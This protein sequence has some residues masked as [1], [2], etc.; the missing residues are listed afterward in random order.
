MSEMPIV[1]AIVIG[2]FIL[3]LISLASAGLKLFS[4][5]DREGTG[6]VK[7]LTVRVA[8]SIGLVMLIIILNALGIISPNG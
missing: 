5:R 1:K 7:A 3:I 6:M 2:V 4:G 8:L